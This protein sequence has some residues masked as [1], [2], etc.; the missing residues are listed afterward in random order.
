MGKEPSKINLQK[1]ITHIYRRPKYQIHLPEIR[2][3][4][5]SID[6]EQR[7]KYDRRYGD[8]KNNS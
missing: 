2:R 3:N 6:S 4:L 7:I 1:I 8:I 5:F